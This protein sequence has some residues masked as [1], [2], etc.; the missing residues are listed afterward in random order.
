VKTVCFGGIVLL[1]SAFSCFC[2]QNTLLNRIKLNYSGKAA[3][4]TSFDV[5]IAWKVRETEETRHGSIV[6]APGDRFRVELGTGVWVSNGNTLWQFD[7]A[8]SQVVIKQLS[9][10]DPSMLPSSAVTR[11][12]SDY[13]LAALQQSGTDAVFEWK[14][15]TSIAARSGQVSFVRLVA[16]KKLAVIEKLVVVDKMGNESSYTF[17]RTVLG[18]IMPSS[19]F[20]FEPPKGARVLDQR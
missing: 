4:A 20:E 2:Q 9:A 10:T 18:K 3:I 19:T 1:F 6:L 11:Y 16:D 8:I 5:H 14:A 7:R 17:S 15:D 12:C 13:P